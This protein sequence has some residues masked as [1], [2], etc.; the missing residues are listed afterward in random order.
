M[1]LGT[2]EIVR[3]AAVRILGREDVVEATFQSET[4]IA[5]PIVKP[6]IKIDEDVY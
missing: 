2:I 5:S 1:A 3:E 4:S 6:S